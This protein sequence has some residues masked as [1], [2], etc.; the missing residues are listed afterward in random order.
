MKPVTIP[1]AELLGAHLLAKLLHHIA[2]LLSISINSCYAWTDSEIVIHW[3]PKSPLLLDRFVANRV[4]AI[5]QLTPPLLWKHVSSGDNPANLA[6]RACVPRT[7]TL[8]VKSGVARASSQSVAFQT[9]IQTCHPGTSASIKPCLLLPPQ[10]V[11]F[12]VKLWARYSSF[13]LL[14]RV[15]GWIRR[16]AF[17]SRLHADQ[18]RFDSQPIASFHCS[19]MKIPLR[20]H[21]TSPTILHPENTPKLQHSV[22]VSSRP[23][24]Q[25]SVS[26][27]PVPGSMSGTPSQTALHELRTFPSDSFPLRSL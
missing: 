22:R 1:K 13:F 9:T 8:V 14:V 12:L 7:C 25:L 20:P 18:R 17:N 6:S 11:Q 19:S 16:F 2:T 23:I 21:L 3:L 27:I 10:T 15:V 4:H 5:Q 26:S 24:Y